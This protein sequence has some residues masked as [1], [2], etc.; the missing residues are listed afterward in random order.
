MTAINYKYSH[1]T[2]ACTYKNYCL[3][4]YF[5]YARRDLKPLSTKYHYMFCLRST[6]YLSLRLEAY[7]LDQFIYLYLVL[8]KSGDSHLNIYHGSLFSPP[9]LFFPILKYHL[10]IPKRLFHKIFLMEHL[11]NALHVIYVVSLKNYTFN[12]IPIV[13][14]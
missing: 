8:T 5:L 6:R 10:A 13:K 9:K 7:C 3:Y 1:A 12:D 4:Y 14:P 11:F 2:Y